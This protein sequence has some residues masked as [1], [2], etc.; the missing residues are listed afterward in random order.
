VKISE[1]RN[2]SSGNCKTLRY[3]GPLI[4]SRFK[5]DDRMP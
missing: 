4:T 2:S 5:D 3:L 1:V